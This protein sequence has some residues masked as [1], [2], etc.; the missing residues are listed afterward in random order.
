MVRELRAL[1][2]LTLSLL[3][4]SREVPPFG[5]AGGGAGVSVLTRADA[6]GGA[7]GSCCS[8]RST[9]DFGYPITEPYFRHLI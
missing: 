8:I 5:L 4:G 1:E 3:S 7:P 6:D 2:P 9:S